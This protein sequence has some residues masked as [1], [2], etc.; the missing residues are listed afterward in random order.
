MRK[1][2]RLGEEARCEV[3]SLRV[4]SG[5]LKGEK[6]ERMAERVAVGSVETRLIVWERVSL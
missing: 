2:T 5:R 4:D 6:T 1:S 3:T